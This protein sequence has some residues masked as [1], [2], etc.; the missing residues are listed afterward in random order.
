MKK[1]VAC[2]PFSILKQPNEGIWKDRI[3]RVL[4]ISVVALIIFR[5]LIT[6]V[7]GFP[8]LV[9]ARKKASS[10]FSDTYFYLLSQGDSVKTGDILAQVGNSGNTDF[11]HLHIHI[12]N[13]ETYDIESTTTYPIRFREFKQNR[14]GYWTNQRKQFILS[15]DII[16]PK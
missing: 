9:L 1:I 7:P 11:P 4:L 6:E 16:K 15:N 2:L 14:Y 13:S 10:G 3:D 5:F 12:Q 8:G